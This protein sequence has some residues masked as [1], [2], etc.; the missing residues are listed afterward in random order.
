MNTCQSCF[1]SEYVDGALFCY[2][3]FDDV[4]LSDYCKE[5]KDYFKLKKK[6]N[7]TDEEML[8]KLR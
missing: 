5:F 2:L 4:G 1:Y 7:C 8:E 6:W 3:I